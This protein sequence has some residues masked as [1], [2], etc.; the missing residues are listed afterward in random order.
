MIAFFQVNVYDVMFK[1]VLQTFSV[2]SFLLKTFI[3]RL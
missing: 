2:Q 3:K 1:N